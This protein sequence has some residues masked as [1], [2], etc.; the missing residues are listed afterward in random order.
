MQVV[1]TLQP[2]SLTQRPMFVCSNLFHLNPIKMLFHT[3]WIFLSCHINLL[4][5][6][7]AKT[8]FMSPNAESQEALWYSIWHTSHFYGASVIV[9]GGR[10]SW[11]LFLTLP[12]RVS[13]SDNTATLSHFVFLTTGCNYLMSVC[14]APWPD[15]NSRLS[16]PLCARQYHSSD[17]SC[18]VSVS[19]LS[20]K[21]PINRRPLCLCCC[22]FKSKLDSQT[23]R[24]TD[25]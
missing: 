21:C 23:D 6:L 9:G 19:V 12:W 20:F 24:Q 1:Y 25:W 22:F 11:D 7:L 16:Y 17:H 13:F 10:G 3:N 15:L 2:E 14:H 5:R 8:T 4:H 18:A